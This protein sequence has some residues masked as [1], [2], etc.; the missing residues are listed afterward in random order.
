M[1]WRVV[2]GPPIPNVKI[3]SRTFSI[4]NLVKLGYVLPYVSNM[5]EDQ[6]SNAWYFFAIFHSPWFHFTV[7]GCCV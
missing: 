1:I 5:G 7:G 2:V 6:R 4:L 3:N